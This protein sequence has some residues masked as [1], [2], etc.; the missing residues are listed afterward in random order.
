MK[1]ILLL[2]IIIFSTINL[3][4][5]ISQGGYPI[6]FDNSN[7]SKDIPTISIEKPNMEKIA[8]EDEVDAKNGNIYRYGRS[9]YTNI[10]ILNDAKK[11]T[12]DDGSKLYRIIV[13]SND[14]KALGIN[15]SKFWIPSDDKLFIYSLDKSQILGAFTSLNNNKHN[16]FAVELLKGSSAII[17]YHQKNDN[18][19]EAKLIITEL[20]Y[21][22]RGIN[23]VFEQ[24]DFGDSDYCQV[25]VNCSPE[26]DNWIDQKKAA[27]RIS[28]KAGNSYGWCSGALINNTTN[29]CTPYVLTADHCAYGFNSYASAND[30]N[31]WVFYFNYESSGCN[32]PSSQ[33]N[34]NT[35]TG[36][37]VVSHS[38]AIGGVNGNIGSTS[39]FWLTELNT[40][41]PPS[42]G[43][44]YAGWDRSSSGSSSGVSI[45]HPAGDI[46]KISTYSSNL[47][48][49]GWNGSWGANTHWRVTW[50][51]TPNGHGVTEGGSSGSPIFNSN[52]QI[53]G[54]LSGGSSFCNN[55]S[56]SDLYGKFSHSWDQ[57]GTANN[58]RLKPW[59]DPINSG[60]TSINGYYCGSSAQASFT[61]NETTFCGSGQHTSTFTSTSTGNINSYNWQF[62]GGSPS[63][64]T[65]PGPH[66]VTY[67]TPGN[68]TVILQIVDNQ[69]NNSQSVIP[70][71][72]NVVNGGITNINFL[73]D[74]Y[75]EET[76]WVINDANNN[77]I[78][79][80]PEGYYPGGS[81]SATMEPNPTMVNHEICLETG[82]YDFVLSDDYGDGLNGSQHSCDFDGDFTITNS[83]GIVLAELNENQYP[84]ADFG[85][86]MTVNF[87]VD[88]SS[89]INEKEIENISI[90]PNP[91]SGLFTINNKIKSNILITDLLGKEVYK[92]YDH[93]G[94]IDI[95]L[96]KEK[97]GLYLI[98]SDTQNNYFIKKL[99]LN[100]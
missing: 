80:I 63:N 43:L 64:A 35:V 87:C 27:C 47:T 74:C 48:N 29:S 18:S 15:F 24:R 17:E 36:C 12:L 49:G 41:P 38:G 13:H 71:Y 22:Y 60:V 9:I 16:I 2:G 86:S 53:I 82:C 81:T 39:D 6:S 99:I 85:N 68:Y 56:A 76:S 5:Q 44:Y 95:D 100:N 59:L 79:S 23:S 66:Q 50:S 46:K 69:G 75:G 33:P 52:G 55:T 93:L 26:G 37:S 90:Y 40:A 65:G 96:S 98:K 7:L 4:A 97:S 67:S 92:I 57:T 54:D 88:N 45:H 31:Q 21:A 83:S 62:A 91:T 3:F 10:N 61:A 78:L 11:E 19:K 72:I 14:A 94:V 77:Q 70:S 8:L 25:N 1:K 58:E 89:N 30:Q 73:P 34:S 32:N 42:Y 20:A 84:N 51:S 28:I